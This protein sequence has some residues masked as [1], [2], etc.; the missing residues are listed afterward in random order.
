[1]QLDPENVDALVAIGIMEL[2]TSEGEVP[3]WIGDDRLYVLL[4]TLEIADKRMTNGYH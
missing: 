3:I 1:M 4:H 2:H